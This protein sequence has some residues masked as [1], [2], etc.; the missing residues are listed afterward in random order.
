MSFYLDLGTLLPELSIFI[1][2]GFQKLSEGEETISAGEHKRWNRSRPKIKSVPI[3]H[4]LCFFPQKYVF[5]LYIYTFIFAASFSEGFLAQNKKNFSNALQS[6]PATL[7][8]NVGQCWLCSQ[9][10]V[11]FL[12]VSFVVL[13]MTPTW[14]RGSQLDQLTTVFTGMGVQ[15]RSKYLQICIIIYS[16]RHFSFDFSIA[17]DTRNF[18]AL[19][20]VEVDCE[21][22]FC[23]FLKLLITE[24]QKGG[25][26]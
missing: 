16:R 20:F 4:G 9:P 23:I 15:E 10:G 22:S 13:L 24:S 18:H 26:E 11:I 19:S 7:A 17:S 25:A 8:M 14:Q 2:Q 12:H 5:A 21:L 3:S 6:N 1:F